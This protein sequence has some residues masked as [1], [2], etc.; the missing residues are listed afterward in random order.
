MPTNLLV[1]LANHTATVL[2]RPSPG[3]PAAWETGPAPMLPLFQAIMNRIEFAYVGLLGQR[4]GADRVSVA[5]GGVANSFSVEATGIESVVAEDTVGTAWVLST[6]D[7]ASITFTQADFAGGTLP[8]VAATYHL[9]LGVG[10]DGSLIREISATAP[11]GTGMV[12]QTG[13]ARRRRWVG[14]FRTT[15]AGAPIPSTTV[16]GRTTYLETIPGGAAITDTA[17]LGA[18]TAISLASLVPS[19]A[20]VAIVDIVVTGGGGSGTS[21]RSIGDTGGD[22]SDQVNH[23]MVL[24]ASQEIEWHTFGAS[25]G[26]TITVRSYE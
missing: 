15:S 22:T 20:R 24:N 16:R 19:H 23:P 7:N 8:A 11:I 12:W 13:T 3:E 1:S 21:Y 17:T 2:T 14:C 26:I 25:G 10:T 9:Y 18:W 5:A 6:D 4:V